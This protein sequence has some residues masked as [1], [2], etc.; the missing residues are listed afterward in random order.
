M[1]KQ[2]V[3]EEIN[4]LSEIYKSKEKEYWEASDSLGK[5]VDRYLK[6]NGKEKDIESLA[7][8]INVLPGGIVRFKLLERYYFLMDKAERQQEGDQEQNGQQIM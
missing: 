3:L 6:E 1:M 2:S 4:R 7:E 5:Y 8:V